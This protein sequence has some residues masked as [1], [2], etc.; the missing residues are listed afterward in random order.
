[1]T[2]QH[3]VLSVSQEVLAVGGVTGV[4]VDLDA[5]ALKLSGEHFSDE[6]VKAAVAEAGYEVI[7]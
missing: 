6:A 2:C 3:C 7:S 5:G 1:M 4:S